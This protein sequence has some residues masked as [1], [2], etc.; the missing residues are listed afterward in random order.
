VAACVA[1]EQDKNATIDAAAVV[2]IK[3]RMIS[4]PY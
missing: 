4:T 1:K 3:V 2:K